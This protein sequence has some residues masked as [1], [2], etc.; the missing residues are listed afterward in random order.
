MDDPTF[1]K[2]LLEEMIQTDATVSFR[3]VSERSEGRFP[4]ATS[5]TRRQQLR[6][7]VEEAAARQRG[8]REVARKFSKSSPAH[9]AERIASLEAEV[10]ELKSQRELLISSHRAAILAIGRMGGIKAWREY[11]PIYSD[12][13]SGMRELGAL[14]DADVV[15]IQ[16]PSMR[17]TTKT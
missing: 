11:F 6:Y 17:K 14:P 1:L 2:S 3:Q 10:R 15:E 13:I 8:V 9:T 12:A 7:A 4:H 5:L 16:S